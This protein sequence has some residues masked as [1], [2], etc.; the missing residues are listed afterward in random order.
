MASTD[1]KLAVAERIR[2]ALEE[3][4]DADE[5]A[6]IVVFESSAGNLR[7]VVP[8]RKFSDKGPV[9]RQDAVW[10]FLKKKLDPKDLVRLY[11]VHAMDPKEFTADE[12]RQRSSA[13]VDLFVRGSNGRGIPETSND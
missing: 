3:F 13:A 6:R 10:D 7:A 9:E 1:D 12:F 8:S 5:R 2:K 11:G 4:V